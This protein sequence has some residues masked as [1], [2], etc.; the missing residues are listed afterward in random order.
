LRLLSSEP[1][2]DADHVAII[3]FSCGG[4]VA[5]LMAFE[6]L[7]SA[8]DP[9]PSRLAAHV[10]FYPGG[11]F[12]AIAEPHAYT[13][14]PVL[15]LLGQ[16]DDNLPMTKIQSYLAYARAAGGLLPRSKP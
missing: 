13:G 7:R 1:R 12:G 6:T 5:H 15:M 3:G 8:L 14:S 4:E 9:G 16:K 2:I 10:A 11:N